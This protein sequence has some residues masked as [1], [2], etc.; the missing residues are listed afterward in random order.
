METVCITETEICIICK[1]DNDSGGLVVLQEK[2]AIGINNA[3]KLRGECVTACVG[4]K[5]HASCRKRFTDKKDIERSKNVSVESEPSTSKRKCRSSDGTFNSKTDCFLCGQLMDVSNKRY[6]RSEFITVRTDTFPKTMQDICEKRNDSW[7]LDVKGRLE[8]FQSDLH[9]ADCVYHH[10]CSTNF[11]I[12][13]GIP[14]QY[15]RKDDSH[16]K[17]K[18]GRPE[19]ELVTE[20]FFRVCS[21]LEENE[22]EQLTVS[23]LTSKMESFLEGSSNTAYAQR[24]MKQKL[25]QHFGDSI[26]ICEQ[27]GKHDIVV[28]RESVN[29]ILRNHYGRQCSVDENIEKMRIIE[30]AARLIKSDIK[31]TIV[32]NKECYPSA[33]D[34]N[35]QQ[36]LEYL[37]PTL[38]LLCSNLFTANDA[39]MKT[40]SIGQCIMQACRPRAITAPLQLSLAVQIAF[41]NG[42]PCTDACGQC[43]ESGCVNFVHEQ[44]EVDSEDSDID[45]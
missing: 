14:Y 11:R 38:K 6:P 2:G 4:D 37:P 10:S 12:G 13:K 24:Y 19:N 40:A 1:K 9:A 21:Y 34:I 32:S 36:C 5:V 41:A 8:Y 39:E 20:A 28:L 27:Q 33:Q 31:T 44:Y 25:I 15:R 17:L 35:I 26:F 7:A 30:T 43:Q 45:E 42:L 29:F 3:S 23:D 18:A 22:D 16:K